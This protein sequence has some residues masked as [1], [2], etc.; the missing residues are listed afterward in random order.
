MPHVGESRVKR[1]EWM[2]GWRCTLIETGGGGDRIRGFREVG[3]PG[4]GVTLEM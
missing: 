1:R 4:K 2:G 3:K